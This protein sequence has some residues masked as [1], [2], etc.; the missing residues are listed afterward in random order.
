MI[1]PSRQTALAYLVLGLVAVLGY[2]LLATGATLLFNG[3]VGPDNPLLLGLA[4]F[5]LAIV[6]QPVLRAVQN[7][8]S[9]LG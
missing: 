6:F 2:A 5:L 7:G 4:A 1:V 9:R 3:L 8:L